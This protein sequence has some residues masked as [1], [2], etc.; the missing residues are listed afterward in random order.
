MED[1]RLKRP[2][3]NYQNAFNGRQSDVPK[4]RPSE[5]HWTEMVCSHSFNR[6]LLAV[7]TFSVA[8][9]MLW[10]IQRGYK[11]TVLEMAENQVEIFH[12]SQQERSLHYTVGVAALIA[13]S[14]LREGRLD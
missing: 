12:P 9:L 2:T 3:C 11:R 13:L 14:V 10:S 8:V 5:A 1:K 6:L 4:G 7:A